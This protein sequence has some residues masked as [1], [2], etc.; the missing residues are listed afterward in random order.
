MDPVT[1][2]LII[3][4]VVLILVI[5]NLCT[6]S[7]Q[8]TTQQLKQSSASEKAI[9]NDSVVVVYADWCGHCKSAKPEFNKAAKM[10]SKV[11]LLNSDTPEGKT[12]MKEHNVKGF[13]TIMKGNEVLNIPRKA[14]AIIAVAEKK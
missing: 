10:S 11:V 5:I 14:D 7:F 13:P 4:A 12:Y 6:S 3:I 1:I 2:F 9:T 8:A